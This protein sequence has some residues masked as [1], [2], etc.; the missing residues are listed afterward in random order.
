MDKLEIGRRIKLAR[1]MKNMTLE[2]IAQKVSVARSTIQRYEA[3]KIERIKFP[4]LES[5]A[6]ALDVSPSWLLGTSDDM[7]QSALSDTPINIFPIERDHLPVLEETVRGGMRYADEEKEIYVKAGTDLRA[8]F[9]LQVKDNSMINARIKNGDIILVRK[10]DMTGNGEIAAVVVGC[11]KEATLKRLYYYR[12]KSLMILR[13]ENP[14]FQD[15]IYVGEE[16]EQVH[17]LG[18]AVAFLSNVK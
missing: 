6:K 11:D 13:S 15:Q 9:C 3:G 4:V 12:E 1:Q 7:V 2:N 18:K 14:S 17:V 5:I 8:D 10:Q 16:L